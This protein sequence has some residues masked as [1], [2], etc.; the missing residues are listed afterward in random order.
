M[1]EKIL[2]LL[3]LKGMV[4]EDT[5]KKGLQK[6]QP[7]FKKFFSDSEKFGY[8]LGATIGFLRSELSQGSAP[9]DKSQRPDQAANQEF[10]RQEQ[11]PG[12]IAGGLAKA[13]AGA[14]IGGLGGAAISGLGSL[15]GSGGESEQQQANPQSNQPAQNIPQNL[16][17]NLTPMQKESGIMP[18]SQG[19]AVQHYNEMQ[20]EKQLYKQLH[21]KYGDFYGGQQQQ[22]APPQSGNLAKLIQLLQQ[23]QQGKI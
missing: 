7:K 10:K 22:G 5:I 12:Q 16:F 14:A 20:K 8:P 19:E 3:G 9:V 15:L 1:L 17:Q 6:V 11:L 13:G 23:R 2:P 21:E 18:K 4:N